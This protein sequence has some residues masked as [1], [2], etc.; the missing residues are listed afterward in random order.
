MIITEKKIIKK[1]IKNYLI[2]YENGIKCEYTTINSKLT[3]YK[4]YNDK[5]NLSYVPDENL[6]KLFKIH[7]SEHYKFIGKLKI[8]EIKK[9]TK[10]DN[11]FY[12]GGGN[13]GMLRRKDGYF[14]STPICLDEIFSACWLH[15]ETKKEKCE[16]IIA[17]LKSHYILESKIVEIPYYNQSDNKKHHWTII[18][19]IKLSDEEY[20]K[21]LGNSIYLDDIIKR[22]IFN[23]LKI[24]TEI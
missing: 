3:S 10:F 4:F 22:N 5:F 6:D 1:I 18:L 20:N 8:T 17:N 21:F 24:N 7:W 13:D 16:K 14:L 12:V 2:D 9:F 15:I 11:L 19:K 23:F